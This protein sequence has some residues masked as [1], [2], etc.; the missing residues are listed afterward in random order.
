MNFITNLWRGG[1][2]GGTIA[3]TL[4]CSVLIQKSHTD[5]S[6]VLQYLLF[7]VD[8]CVRRNSRSPMYD[9]GHRPKTPSALQHSC[10][11]QGLGLQVKTQ[12]QAQQ[13]Q[14]SLCL[15]TSGQKGVPF[16]P[17]IS[18]LNSDTEAENPILWKSTVAILDEESLCDDHSRG[19]HQS[20]LMGKWK[21][22]KLMV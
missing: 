13:T 8:G 12:K 17:S 11:F 18:D 4:F 14:C 3:N 21:E 15:A 2:E 6:E 19:H 9:R 22:K 16:G 1:R 10:C 5:N 20:Q 7:L